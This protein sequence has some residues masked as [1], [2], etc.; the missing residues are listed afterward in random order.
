MQLTVVRV[1]CSAESAVAVDPMHCE[2]ESINLLQKFQKIH[3]VMTLE[4]MT[5]VRKVEK[6]W[7]I[8]NLFN[9][10]FKFIDAINFETFY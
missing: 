4:M 6:I 7:I 9:F 2:P 1:L 5:N 10:F 3:I 8:W